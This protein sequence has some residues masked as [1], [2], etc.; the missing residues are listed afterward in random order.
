MSYN[1]F[2]LGIKKDY[3]SSFDMPHACISKRL[4]P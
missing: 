2:D 3:I 4:S 1:F